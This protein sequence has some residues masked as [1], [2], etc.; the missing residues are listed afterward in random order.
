[1]LFCLSAE[2]QISV[3]DSTLKGG[4]YDGR[5]FFS[6]FFMWMT[7]GESMELRLLGD[8]DRC[9]RRP[10]GFENVRETN[11]A[12]TFRKK[13]SDYSD[14]RFKQS[15]NQP[16]FFFLLIFY[17]NINLSFCDRYPMDVVW[18]AP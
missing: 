18:I 13:K 5:S 2:F 17:I 1:M 4:R 16:W 6:S 11:G 15:R 8:L 10:P 14:Y 3:A 9:T 12:M 7:N